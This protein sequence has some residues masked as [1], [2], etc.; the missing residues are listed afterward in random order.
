MKHISMKPISD[1]NK[2]LRPIS[3]TSILSKIG[4]GFVVRDFVKPAV[5]KKIGNEQFG[6][7]PKSSTTQALI[8]MLHCWNKA[9]D[10][11]GSSSC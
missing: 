1:V 7:V 9:T 6:T 11:S 8:S 3:L 10:G 5:L 4:E 2:Y